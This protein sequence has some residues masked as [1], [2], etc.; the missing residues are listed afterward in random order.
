MHVALINEHTLVQ[1]IVHTSVGVAEMLLGIVVTLNLSV[2]TRPDPCAHPK[3]TGP[4]TI[5]WP[6]GKIW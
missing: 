4:M 2:K 1:T 3:R 6:T 5:L